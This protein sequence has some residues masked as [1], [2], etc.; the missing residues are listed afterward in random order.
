MTINTN[1]LRGRAQQIELEASSTIDWAAKLREAAIEIDSAR[2]DRESLL[3]QMTAAREALEISSIDLIEARL[4]AT[5][6][7]GQATTLQLQVDNLTAEVVRLTAELARLTAP[8]VEP[9][10]PPPPPVEPPPPPPPPVEP[11]AFQPAITGEPQPEQFLL[12][13]TGSGPNSRYYDSH[14]GLPWGNLDTGDWLDADGLAQGAK[15]FSSATLVP[16]MALTYVASDVTDLVGSLI[17]L[18]NPGIRLITPGGVVVASGRTSGHAPELS[19]TTEAGTFS[20]PCTASAQWSNRATGAYAV[21][22]RAAFRFGSG[23]FHAALRFDLSGVDGE[24][25]TSA[26]LRLFVEMVSGQRVAIQTFL[27]KAKRFQ[28]GAGDMPPV[29]GLAAEVGE[30]NLQGHPDVW[31]AGDF[32]GT[33]FKP[34]DGTADVPKLFGRVN[35]HAKAMS[36]V[37]PDPDAPGTV[38]WRGSFAPTVSGQDPARQAF[39]GTYVLMRP[40]LDDPLRPAVLPVEEA[41]YRMYIFLEDDWGTVYDGNKMGLTWDLRGGWWNPVGYWQHTTGNGGTRGSGRR[42]LRTIQN[43]DKTFRQQWEYQGHM[44][45]MESGQRPINAFPQD[46]IRPITGYNY[47]IDQGGPF[48]GGE[49]DPNGGATYSNIVPAKL[50]KG[51]WYCIEQHLRMNSIDMS[52]PDAWGNGVARFDGLLETEV[53]G[54]LVDRRDNYRWRHHPEM[55]IFGVNANWYLGGRVITNTTMHFRMNHIVLARRRIGPRVRP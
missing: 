15:P 29:L 42:V 14:L 54:V 10:P 48:P 39:D 38:M 35:A 8:P 50:T 26:T 44:E 20:C 16:A 49:N 41:W 28:L 6:A 5:T 21:D 43:Q 11:G 31:M 37:L 1:E 12:N 36:E 24:T 34:V 53:N 30:A 23:V 13:D 4:Q 33:T 7:L 18:G 40:N 17:N 9:P 22:S 19:V 55:G 45:R 2:S 27:L 46:H 51:R 47:H 3:L 25:I 32:A 52:N